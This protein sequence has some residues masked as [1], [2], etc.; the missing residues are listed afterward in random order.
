MTDEAAVERFEAFLRAQ[1]PA[2]QWEPVTDYS[3]AARVQAE[4]KHPYLIKQVFAPQQVLDYGCGFGHLVSMLRW[5]GVD[6]V[7]YE[8]H[9]RA[10]LPYVSDT[11]DAEAMY[12]LVICREV[13]EHCT[14]REVVRVVRA[15][16]RHSRRF[17]Y[18]TTRF[19]K[20]PDHLLSVET[21][22]DVDPTHITCLTKPFLRT[23]FVLEGCK[24]R[25]DLEAQMD[26]QHKGRVL[27]FEVI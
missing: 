25:P 27:V 11:L 1:E 22:F 19:A 20:Q 2:P 26:W 5:A 9:P 17:I 24:S 14:V 16:V 13:M 4:G 15:L 23:L 18:V 12:D 7:G 6:A 3:Y 10:C 21:E 8:P